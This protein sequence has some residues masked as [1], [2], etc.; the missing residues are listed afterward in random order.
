MSAGARSADVRS[1][2]ASGGGGRQ[3]DRR[4]CARLG[5]RR[6]RVRARGRR[7]PVDALRSALAGV[8]SHRRAVTRDRARSADRDEGARRC[9]AARRTT[10]RAAAVRVRRPARRAAPGRSRLTLS[11]DGDDARR[12][13]P[14]RAGP[15]SSIAGAA[16]PTERE[17]ACAAV[18]GS[19]ERRRLIADRL[20]R[21]AATSSRRPVAATSTDRARRRIRRARRGRTG[22]GDRI[23]RRSRARRI[24]RLLGG[25]DDELRRRPRPDVASTA[26]A[27]RGRAARVRAAPSVRR[28]DAAR[29]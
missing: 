2:R 15:R 17:P 14:R 20:D 11:G 26:S 9:R 16:T 1:R 25:A 5:D 4:R 18:A 21:V 13:A 6:A 28:A 27:R 23:P 12:A 7:C 3:R 8:R 22:E 19:F 10:R 29:R 24:R